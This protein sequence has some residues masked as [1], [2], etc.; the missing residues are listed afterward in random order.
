ME[1]RR[2]YIILKWAESSDGFIGGGPSPWISN[3]V[4]RQLV[5]RWR[6]EE[7]AVLVGT[8]TAAVDN[9][10]LNVRDW[11]GRN[12]VRIVVDRHLRLDTSLH[13]FDQSQKT[14]CYNVTRDEEKENLI[15][16]KVNEQNP[17]TEMLSDLYRRNVQSVIVEGGAVTLGLFIRAGLWDEARVFRAKRHLGNGI[18]APSLDAKLASDEPV[19]GDSLLLYFRQQEP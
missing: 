15:L 19:S 3:E 2:P 13:V 18:A 8:N 5:H 4:S 6:T 11:T 1:Q 17:V 9:P 10:R 12:P 7:D 16:V 14:L